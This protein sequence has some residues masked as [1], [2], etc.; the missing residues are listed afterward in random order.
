MSVAVDSHYQSDSD[1]SGSVPS[2]PSQMYEHSGSLASGS[3]EYAYAR[4][5][6]PP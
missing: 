3:P 6:L 1:Y 4:D 5:R 2:Y